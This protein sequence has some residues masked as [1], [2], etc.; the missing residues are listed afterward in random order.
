MKPFSLLLVLSLALNA[1]LVVA[2]KSHDS[3]VLISEGNSPASN[4]KT[5]TSPIPGGPT[6]GNRADSLR[7]PAT[8]PLEWKQLNTDDLQELVRRL[9]LAGFPPKIVNRIISMR[10][11][12]LFTAR[13]NALTGRT[14]NLE[15]WKSS[16]PFPSDPKKDSA[17]AS[18]GME[19]FKLLNQL[20]G[21]SQQFEWEDLSDHMSHIYGDVSPEKL[22]QI[23]AIVADYTALGTEARAA[24]YAKGSAATQEDRNKIS[25]IDQ[26]LKKEI[27]ALLTPEEQ[28]LTNLRSSPAAYALRNE[29]RL[30]RTTEAEFLALLPIYESGTQISHLDGSL[31]FSSD[32]ALQNQ[33]AAVLG[34]DRYAEYQQA[35]NPEFDK[36]N[37]IVER[38]DLPISTAVSLGNLQ[39]ETIQQAETIRADPALTPDQRA[40]QLTALANDASAKISDSLGPRGF[41]AYKRYSARWLQALTPRNGPPKS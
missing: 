26:Q 27:F 41:E 4:S 20:L 1:T 24:F 7:V 5:E 13:R 33:I 22:K 18:L 19:Q 3:P 9:R 15:Y 21:P 31:K 23:Q 40:S 39:R 32:P 16:S 8:P 11:N 29:T 35:R 34:P 37:R 10:V 28:R 14:T 38:L 6:A 25:L 30:F 36:L 2:L 12:E 17:L